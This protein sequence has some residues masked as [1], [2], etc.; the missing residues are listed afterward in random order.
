MVNEVVAYDDVLA[1]VTVRGA[2]VRPRASKFSIIFKIVRLGRPQSRKIR[3]IP[4]LPRWF[5]Y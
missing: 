5:Y 2:P 3:E 4:S 1:R